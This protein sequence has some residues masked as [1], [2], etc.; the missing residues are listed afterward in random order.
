MVIKKTY[1]INFLY[2]R[3]LTLVELLIVVVISGMMMLGI[4]AANLGFRHM[5]KTASSDAQLYIKTLAMAEEIKN[6]ARLAVGDDVDK[7]VFLDDATDTMCFRTAMNATMTGYDNTQWK[8]Y[9]KIA[10]GLY[11]CE[12]TTKPVAGVRCVSTDQWIGSL[13]TDAY[14]C[15]DLCYFPKLSGNHLEF[16]FVARVTSANANVSGSGADAKFVNNDTNN[17]QVVISQ[18]VPLLSHSF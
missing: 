15:P 13:V 7:G 9:T 16:Q 8:C 18:R 2:R 6:N 10:N 4:T 1:Q 11:R 14:T 12:K 5:E 17:P 3:A